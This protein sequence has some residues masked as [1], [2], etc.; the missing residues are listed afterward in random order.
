[1]NYKETAK[2]LC[3]PSQHFCMAKIMPPWAEGDPQSEEMV[4]DAYTQV[5]TLKRQCAAL[6]ELFPAKREQFHRELDA[7]ILKLA[8]KVHEQLYN[9]EA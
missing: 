3:L 8:E 4:R 1:M 5:Q 9:L 7:E 2:A 6:I